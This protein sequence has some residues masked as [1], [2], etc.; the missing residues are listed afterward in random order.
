VPEIVQFRSLFG[1]EGEDTFVVVGTHCCLAV[2]AWSTWC[3]VME[4]FG[5]VT[6]EK[7]WKK[8]IPGFILL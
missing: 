6:P 1:K 4:N 8:I 5:S 7:D 2:D 3:H